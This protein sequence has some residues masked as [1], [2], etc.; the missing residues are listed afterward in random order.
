MP[1]WQTDNCDHG[2][3]RLHQ[4]RR[5]L[6]KVRTKRQ[7][8]EIDDYE[9]YGIGLCLDGWPQCDALYSPRFHQVFA[10]QVLLFTQGELK[11]GV[12][13]GG[14]FAL[15]HELTRYPYSS[16]YDIH[17][18][19]WDLEFEELAKQH[20]RPI[21][22][23]SWK[24][25]RVRVEINHPDVFEYL[26][27][28]YERYHVIFGDLTDLSVAEGLLP[29][30][31]SYIKERLLPNGKFITQAG[32]LSRVPVPLKKFLD[33]L[34]FLAPHF[35]YFWISRTHI[36]FF[37]YE[38]VFVLA[39]DDKNFCPTM[40]SAGYIDYLIRS[41]IGHLLSDYSGAVHQSIFALEPALKK[42]IHGVLGSKF[43]QYFL[44]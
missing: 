36:P 2:I 38:Q 31:G 16:V 29:N 41:K 28:T 17:I 37:G 19:D 22:H 40:F 1:V 44:A 30:F 24:D 39:T 6:V 13:G 8:V 32:E 25:P 26:P 4:L 7:L 34:K 20:L 21:H 14:D 42:I 43:L 10:H 11:L 27:Q 9:N 5:S 33:G 35:R 15:T 18:I 3:I 12:L 23:D